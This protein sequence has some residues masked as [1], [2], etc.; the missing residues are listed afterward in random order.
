[1]PELWRK[2]TSVV[3]GIGYGEETD[4]LVVADGPAAHGLAEHVSSCDAAIFA[5]SDIVVAH[6]F[7]VSACVQHA[8]NSSYVC[9]AHVLHQAR[10]CAACHHAVGVGIAHD[11]AYGAAVVRCGYLAK[12]ASAY[13]CFIAD[14]MSHKAADGAA[15]F[16]RAAE[17]AGNWFVRLS[18]KAAEDRRR[19][20]RPRQLYVCHAFAVVDGAKALASYAANEHLALDDDI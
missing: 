17:I 20:Y 11:A 10:V 4:A 13:L 6:G 9:S 5:S 2:E 1:M 8:D 18:H 14:G 7:C 19:V 15:S 12:V 3:V 16:N